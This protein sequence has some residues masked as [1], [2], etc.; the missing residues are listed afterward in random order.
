LKGFEREPDTRSTL[1]KALPQCTIFGV[2]H[3]AMADGND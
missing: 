2:G 3:D 1:L